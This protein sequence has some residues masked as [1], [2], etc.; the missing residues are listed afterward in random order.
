VDEAQKSKSRA[1]EDLTLSRWIREKAEVLPR[2]ELVALQLTSA[3]LLFIDTDN[4]L[5]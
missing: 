4:E 1:E 5:S 3:S 2:R